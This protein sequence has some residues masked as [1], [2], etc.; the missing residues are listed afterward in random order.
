[1][2]RR[3]NP[4]IDTIRG[5]YPVKRFGKPILHYDTEF[6]KSILFAKRS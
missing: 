4:R 1:M 2:L 5:F 6:G 3:Q